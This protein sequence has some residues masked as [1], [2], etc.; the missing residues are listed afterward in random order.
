MGLSANEY[1][2]DLEVAPG[3]VVIAVIPDL[4]K[5]QSGKQLEPKVPV[6][7]LEKIAD[8][9]R[10]KTSPFARLK[11][12]N[13]RYEPVDVTIS[14]RLYRGKSTSFYSK[15]L[16]EDITGFLAPWFLGDSEKLAFG[17]EIFFSDVVGF[18]ESLDYVDFIVNLELMG[19]C[20]QNG[21][22]IKPLTS[23]SILTGGDIC[24][25]IS[26]EECPDT[27][28]ILVAGTTINKYS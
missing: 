26:E 2:R 19:L 6:S 3:Y 17:Q 24:V 1:R 28:P 5:L 7:L 4:T 10:S 23:R 22:V 15:K 18:V 8:H 14:V 12:M 9:V 13:P 11:I 21:S 25:K 16:K 20:D 27:T